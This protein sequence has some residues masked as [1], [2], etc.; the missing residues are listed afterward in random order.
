[1][2]SHSKAWGKKGRYGSPIE[3]TFSWFNRDR[4]LS[5]DSE[6]L[7]PTSEALIYIT[8]TRLMLRRLAPAC[9]FQTVSY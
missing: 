7:C 1:M 5:E 9:P 4:R 3:R 8:M 6:R 2:L